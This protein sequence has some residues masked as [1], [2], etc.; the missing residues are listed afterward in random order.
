MKKF[1]IRGGRLKFKRYT[2]RFPPGERLEAIS[3]VTGNSV[4]QL[5]LQICL[6]KLNLDQDKVRKTVNLNEFV[7]GILQHAKDVTGQ[8]ANDLFAWALLQKLRY[9]QDILEELS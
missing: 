7:N 2:L 6:D 8:P 4:S 3:K 9:Y 5:N 1:E